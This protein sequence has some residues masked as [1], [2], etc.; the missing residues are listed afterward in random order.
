MKKEEQNCTAYYL[1]TI[2]YVLFIPPAVLIALVT[3]NNM[4]MFGNRLGIFASTDFFLAVAPVMAALLMFLY[5]YLCIGRFK[6]CKPERLFGIYLPILVNFAWQFLLWI[7][8]NLLGDNNSMLLMAILS[9]NL[10]G[11][12]AINFMNLQIS[13]LVSWIYNA[14]VLGGFIAGERLAA[15]KSGIIPIPFNRKYVWSITVVCASG[16][17]LSEG[18]WFYGR[19]NI[20]ELEPESHGYGFA[21]EDGLSSTD[22]EP[23]Y[24][25]NEDNILAKLDTKASFTI[26]D[27]EQMPILDGAEAA[28]PIYSAFANTCYE[29]IDGIQ[30]AAKE[31][32]RKYRQNNNIIMPIEF[33]NSVIAFEHLLEGECDIFFGARPSADQ[34]ELAAQAGKELL[35]TPI[36]KEAFIFFVNSD[37]PVDGLSTDQ[38]RQIYSGRINNWKKVGG[39]NARIL[40]FQR[41][42]NSGSQTMME[43]F[44]GDAVL[45]EPLETEYVGS[46]GDLIMHTANYQNRSTAL[47]YSFRYFVLIMARDSANTSQIKH[48]S[49]DGVYPDVDAIQSGAYPLTTELYA[50]MTA[51]NPNPNVKRFI[52][53]MTSPE[54]QKIVSDTGYVALE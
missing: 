4:N 18:V 24:V 50:V 43:Y 54:G 16:L 35:L 2:L 30:S 53:W 42:Q 8:F 38:L 47:G 29:N 9:F 49:V 37:N 34:Q 7:L 46:M 41:P 51:D 6:L 39:E 1:W 11:I 28:Y 15:R 26:S 10:Y 22:L 3:I 17:L 36:G 13:Q 45:K 25:E 33:N 20:I 48:L 19:R 31:S 44:M 23:Y 14:A 5:A 52:D 40:A 21:Y 27:A 32:G 12:S